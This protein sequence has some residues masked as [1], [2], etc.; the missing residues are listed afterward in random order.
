MLLVMV[1]VVLLIGT[2][3]FSTKKIILEDTG[4]IGGLFIIRVIKQDPPWCHKSV[5]IF[6]FFFGVVLNL[7]V[8]VLMVMVKLVWVLIP[9]NLPPRKLIFGLMVLI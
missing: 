7:V 5:I 6:Q 8:V 2:H 3:T 1:E 4:R 9:P